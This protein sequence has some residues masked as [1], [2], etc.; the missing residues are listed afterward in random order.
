[1]YWPVC[2]IKCKRLTLTFFLTFSPTRYRRQTYQRTRCR[3][4]TDRRLKSESLNSA[5]IDRN[6]TEIKPVRFLSLRRV[7]QF[8]NEK[9]RSSPSAIELPA[10]QFLA[11][12]V[13]ARA[14]PS[15]GDFGPNV[16]PAR[17][18]QIDSPN[19]RCS[20]FFPV[21]S[22]LCPSRSRSRVAF[23][24]CRRSRRKTLVNYSY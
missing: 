4:Y 19:Y 20:W 23:C 24:G 7:I 14:G 10:G 22:P 13:G 18:V 3:H 16:P 1:M 17:R 2:V 5:K 21:S 15:P 12:G 6:K 11:N 8:R 9:Y